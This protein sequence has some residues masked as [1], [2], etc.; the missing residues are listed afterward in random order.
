MAEAKI[1]ISLSDGSVLEIEG[2]EGFVEKQ[3]ESFGD[4][5]KQALVAQ[6]TQRPAASTKQQGSGDE[7]KDTAPPPSAKAG[8]NP[9]PNV[10]EIQDGKVTFIMEKIPGDNE[11][12][13][14]VDAALLCILGNELA[15]K[16]E[17]SF[18]AMKELSKQ[19]G[20]TSDMLDGNFSPYLKSES[21]YFIFGG[22]PRKQTAKLSNPGR[23]KAKELAAKLNIVAEVTE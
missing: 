12:D 1:R 16:P 21:R 22:T 19:H 3:I 6:S 15:G 23:A 4:L 20:S 17:V 14:M 2:S 8:I 5:I 18:A 13:K 10:F 9:Y 7:Q 11:K